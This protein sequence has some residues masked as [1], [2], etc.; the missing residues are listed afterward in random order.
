MNK[1]LNSHLVMPAATVE[2]AQKLLIAFANT[3]SPTAIFRALPGYD[4]ADIVV[5]PLG[6][7]DSV[8]AQGSTCISQCKN[9]WQLLSE[10][11][12]ERKIDGPIPK[13]KGRRSEQISLGFM[14]DGSPIGQNVWPVLEWLVI[15]FERDE[16]LTNSEQNCTSSSFFSVHISNTR[17][18]TSVKYSPLL[19]SQLPSSRGDNTARWEVDATLD[20]IFFCLHQSADPRKFLGYRLLTLVSRCPE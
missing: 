14:E 16:S 7:Y 6:Q 12:V 11:F 15:I 13:A 18:C 4:S 9:C 17:R 10:G 8:I 1:Q 3:N 5:S 2:A 19:L 20:V